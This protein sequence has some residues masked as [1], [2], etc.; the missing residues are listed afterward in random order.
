MG[1]NPAQ[2]RAARGLLAMTQRDLAAASNVSLRAIQHFE[3]AKRQPIPAT[4]AAI[5]RAFEAAGAEFIA[6][7]GGGPGVRLRKSS[8][9]R[10]R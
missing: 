8:K 5:E 3:A 7:D 4:L 6:A 9:R 1:I 10:G 2:C